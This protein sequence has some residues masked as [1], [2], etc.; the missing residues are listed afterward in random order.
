MSKAPNGY[1]FTPQEHSEAIQDLIR[2]LDLKDLILVVQDWGGP[3]GLNCAVRHRKDRPD[4]VA[5][6]IRRIMNR[7]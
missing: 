3:I 1:R 2:R 7:T 6:S 4:R 5:A